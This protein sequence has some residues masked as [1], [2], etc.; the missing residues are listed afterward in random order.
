MA[1][2]NLFDFATLKR[3]CR[4]ILLLARVGTEQEIFSILPP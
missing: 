2:D 3:R 1:L 4:R